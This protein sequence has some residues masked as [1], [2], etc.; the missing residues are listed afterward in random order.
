MEKKCN[1]ISLFFFTPLFSCLYCSS[2]RGGSNSRVAIYIDVVHEQILSE[3]AR[4]TSKATEK[5]T[6]CLS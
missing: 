5:K 3:R 6:Q 1:N 2:L 4:L